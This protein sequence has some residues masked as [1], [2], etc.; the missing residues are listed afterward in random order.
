MP[1]ASQP[2]PHSRSE[3]SITQGDLFQTTL[4]VINDQGGRAR[5]CEVYDAVA[6]RLKVSLRQRQE[7]RRCSGHRSG[8]NV[9][10]RNVRWAVQKAKS[11][12]LLRSP[13]FG[14]WELTGKGKNALTS[15]QRGVVLAVIVAD[16]GVAYWGLSED[17]LG[18]IEPGSV[19]LAV[20]SPPYPL[21]REKHYG[22]CAVHEYND[23]LIRIIERALPTLSGDGSLV[24][25][26]GEAWN[27]GEP[28]QST[29]AERLLIRLE[30]DLG[31]KLCQRMAWHNPSKLPAPAQWVTVEKCRVKPSLEHVWWL[32]PSSRPKARQH[33]VLVEYSESMKSRL[34]AGGERVGKERPSGHALAAGSFSNDRGGAIPP[35]LISAANTESNSRYLRVCRDAGLP[36][37]PARFPLALPEFFVR[38]C[39]DPGDTVLDFFGG[40]GTSAEAA[41]RNGRRWVVIDRMLEYLQGFALRMGEP[42]PVRPW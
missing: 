2:S 13:R 41:R 3:P 24:L 22:N 32:S 25:N 39:T 6:E 35:A 33:E 34:A 12:G 17:A 18:L 40:S 31:L 30:D 36:V 1:A 20:T 7:K 38:L 27:P 29:F 16:D 8:F 14:E 26:V 28:T 23:W 42:M 19:Q 4:E 21:L 11:R 37:H 15:T 5:P 9:F 10:E